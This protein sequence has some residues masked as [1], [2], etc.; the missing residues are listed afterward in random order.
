MPE[1]S[2]S[3]PL[4]PRRMSLPDGDELLNPAAIAED[5]PITARGFLS[6]QARG[7]PRLGG[8]SVEAHPEPHRWER[9]GLAGWETM[10]RKS[11]VAEALAPL[12]EFDGHYHDVPGGPR[13]NVHRTRQELGTK[14]EPL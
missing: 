13:Y 6:R 8:A 7:W 5:F 1:H 9:D 14:A 12:P 2:P 11:K 3:E 10:Y 4:Y